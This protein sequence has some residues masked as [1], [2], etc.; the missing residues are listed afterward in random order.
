[1]LNDSSI[2]TSISIQALCTLCR[3]YRSLYVICKRSL[4]AVLC[5]A[6]PS[7]SQNIKRI[8]F[9]YSSPRITHDPKNWNKF[10]SDD[11]N[12][13]GLEVE[14]RR[15][16]RRV[17][18]NSIVFRVGC[19]CFLLSLFLLSPL[20]NWA[21]ALTQLLHYTVESV[22]RSYKGNKYKHFEKSL[23]P[24][25]FTDIIMRQSTSAFWALPFVNIFRTDLLVAG[26]SLWCRIC[27]CGSGQW[28][29]VSL[30]CFSAL[31]CIPPFLCFAVSQQQQ[32]HQRFLPESTAAAAVSERR[33]GNGD[34]TIQKCNLRK[35]DPL[36]VE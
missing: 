11:L 21:R 2:H 35:W 9:C 28:G 20:Y 8:F 14:G 7:T 23:A 30:W 31:H 33:Q 16:K 5:S 1:M 17:H 24:P 12:R 10:P 6:L 4:C 27:G 25:H 29:T 26:F 3:A 22:N 18:S 32:Q 19:I 36:Y 15:I 34:L 13:N